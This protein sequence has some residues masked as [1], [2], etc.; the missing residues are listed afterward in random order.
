L[1]NYA[2][3]IEDGSLS[4]RAKAPELNHVREVTFNRGKPAKPDSYLPFDFSWSILLLDGRAMT[5]DVQAGQYIGG[6]IEGIFH[7]ISLR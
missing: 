2:G 5:V 1:K 3:V 4:C 7:V 6:G